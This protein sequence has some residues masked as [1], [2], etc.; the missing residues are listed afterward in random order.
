MKIFMTV[1]RYCIYN[2]KCFFKN[3]QIYF[4]DNIF[5]HIPILK[6]PFLSLI[7]I[8]V[9][10]PFWFFWF[11]YVYDREENKQKN[12]NEK[13]KS[14][15]STRVVCLYVRVCYAIIITPCEYTLKC[16]QAPLPQPG[17]F[18]YISKIVHVRNMLRITSL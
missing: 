15:R 7:I 1:L 8:N 11:F 18:D 9:Y 4:I 6:R 2:A 16:T 3:L 14:D 13:R 10:S 17:I 12:G 5:N